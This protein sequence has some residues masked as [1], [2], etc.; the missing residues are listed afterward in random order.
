LFGTLQKILSRLT[1][2]NLCIE[3]ALQQL[4]KSM[5]SKHIYFRGSLRDGH[6]SHISQR[7]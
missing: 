1:R 5:C 2:E 4:N 7:L 6:T 3:A